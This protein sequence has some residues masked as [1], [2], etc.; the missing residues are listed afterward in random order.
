MYNEEL[1]V[2]EIVAARDS[3]KKIPSNRRCATAAEKAKKENPEQGK[4]YKYR[5]TVKINIK[6]RESLSPEAI[7]KREKIIGDTMQRMVGDS[8]LS[9][10]DDCF[11]EGRIRAD[12][13][14]A[15]GERNQYVKW[16]A[17][18]SPNDRTYFVGAG[19]SSNLNDVA[20]AFREK[21][22]G[23]LQYLAYDE[24]SVDFDDFVFDIGVKR[25]I[26]TRPVVYKGTHSLYT[27]ETEEGSFM[28]V[29]YKK[30]K[31]IVPEAEA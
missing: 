13:S 18:T 20:F 12:Q 17:L 3:L 29:D 16:I 11:K 23:L 24:E 30:P 10:A 5:A 27:L 28:G 21:I 19:S 31:L 6:N 22:F 9:F 4:L 7:E 14:Y 15:G 1:T 2:E 26:K 25:I 8:F